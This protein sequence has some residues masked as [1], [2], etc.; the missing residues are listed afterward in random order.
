MKNLGLLMITVGF[1]GGA[2][3]SVM[4]NETVRWGY[5]ACGMGL[6]VAGVVVTRKGHRKQSTAEGKL[7]ENIEA[8]E[9]SLG[10]IV[11]NITR[12]DEE[13]ESISPYDF[14]HKVDELFLEEIARFVE[15]RESIG[16]LFGLNAYGEVMTRFAAG[17]RYLNRVWS[18]SADG[19]VDEVN[20]Y[21]GKAREQFTDSLERI[22]QL[23]A[24][25]Q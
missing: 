19:Y 23:K 17:E 15:A 18:A 6:G 1:L 12:L 16:H 14:R 8:V 10:N 11:E 24:T 5:F 13:K 2:L 25:A 20:D 9:T 4:D 21:V 22:R 3:A 7:A